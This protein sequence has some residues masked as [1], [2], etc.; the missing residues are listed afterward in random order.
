MHRAV[1]L[2]G[3]QW[4]GVPLLAAPPV[5]ALCG[6]LGPGRAGIVGRVALVYV[7]MLAGLRVLGNATCH[8]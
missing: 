1:L 6:I 4:L 5:L 7:L 8:R 3:K 2:T